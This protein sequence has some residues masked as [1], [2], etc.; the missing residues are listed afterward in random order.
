MIQFAPARPRIFAALARSVAPRPPT[1]VSQWAESK[2]R[3][4]SKGSKEPGRFRIARNPLLQEPMDCM[5]TRSTVAEMVVRFPIQFGKS[6]MESAVLGYSM[7]E[8]PGPIMVCL[9]GEVSLEKFVN[10]KL[11]PLLEETESL[12]ALLSSTASRDGANTKTFKDFAGGQLY[13]E[14]AGNPKRLKSTS[15]KILLLDEWS[16]FASSLTSGDDPGELV[17][18]RVSA[19]PSVSKIMKVSTP[20]IAGACRTSSDFEDSD[21]RYP[22]V[23]CPHC[24]QMQYLQWSGL[25]WSK[26]PVTG[27]VSRAW[28]VC[29]GE[30]GCGAI[31]EEHHK[32]AMLAG[33]RWVPSNPGH[34][35][36]GY[37]ANCLYYPIGLGPRW[38]EL[39]QMWI[40]AQGDQTRLKTFINDRLAEPWED[41]AL[42]AVKNNIIRDRAEPYRLRLVPMAACYLTAG[43]DTQ[44]DRLEIQIVAWGKGM[45]GWVIDYHVIDSDPALDHTWDQLTA[46]L[47]QR[48]P[49]ESGAELPVSATLIDGRGHRTKFVK[50]FALSRRLPRIMPGFGAKAAN[51][52]VLGRP[53]W[54]EVDGAGKIEKGGI[55]TWS[56]GTIEAKHTLFRNMAADADL[57]REA[58]KL[59]FSDELPEPYWSGVTGEVFDPKQGRY[60]KKRG[61]KR[62]EPLDTLVYA[63]AAA[64][65][66]ELHL[67]RLRGYEW[68]EAHAR[69]IDSTAP[70]AKED[71][72]A[73][74]GP[75]PQAATQ[76][77]A[78][79]AP[80][81][82]APVIPTGRTGRSSYLR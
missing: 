54:E 13:L 68:D 37:H 36:R 10:Q 35:R 62:N 56:V 22:H 42:R 61:I 30:D 3:L 23:P 59:H 70:R 43:V 9:P 6:T 46:Y 17:A 49:H 81:A 25:Q 28:Y 50:A 4:S 41:P 16:E 55:Q 5:S 20:G 7:E 29:G 72:P 75:A 78:V 31:I 34:P 47:S 52:P 39:A 66:P 40:S 21:Q 12:K 32:P 63:Y 11:N 60:V 24:G 38:H 65:H 44:D 15:V 79:G 73:L 2:L 1:T 27:R 45:V 19:F 48:I 69:I 33:V 64:H 53:K 71:P 67:H 76:P 14:H 77:P 74:R 26:D 80:V 18:G 58:R 51:A 82:S 57:A 8:N